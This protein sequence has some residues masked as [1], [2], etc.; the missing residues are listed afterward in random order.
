MTVL[1]NVAKG[2]AKTPGSAAYSLYEELKKFLKKEKV[3]IG[4]DQTKFQIIFSAF[5]NY[6]VSALFTV[7]FL[8]YAILC[9]C[10]LSMCF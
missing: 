8:F 1:H 2:K 6:E 3:L 10:G 4:A 9:G 5:Q 7:L